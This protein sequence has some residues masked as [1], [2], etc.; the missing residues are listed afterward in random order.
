MCS[1]ARFR[2]GVALRGSERKTAWHVFESRLEFAVVELYA[3][4]KNPRIEEHGNAWHGQHG[5]VQT[6][7]G[8]S[9]HNESRGIARYNIASDIIV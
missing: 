5:K 8:E 4:L 3:E 2:H 9:K 6:K 1:V 7:Q